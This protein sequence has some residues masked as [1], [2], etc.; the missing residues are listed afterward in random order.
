MLHGVMAAVTVR[1]VPRSGRTAVE[2]GPEGVVVRV[3]ATPEHGRATEEARRALARALDVPAGAVRL[4]TGAR[5][6]TKVFEVRGLEADELDRR[7][8]ER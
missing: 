8:R 7:L 5:A 3:R 4:R 2:V 1:V 6:R